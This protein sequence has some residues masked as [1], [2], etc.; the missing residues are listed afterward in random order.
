MDIVAR[1]DTLDKQILIQ[2]N[3]TSPDTPPFDLIEKDLVM[4]ANFTLEIIDETP[5]NKSDK[6]SFVAAKK[7]CVQKHHISAKL[8]PSH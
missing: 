3:N 4:K 7:N 8:D 6:V 2:V 1:S 5:S